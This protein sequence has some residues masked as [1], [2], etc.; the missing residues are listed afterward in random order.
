MPTRKTAYLAIIAAGALWGTI[1]IFVRTLTAAGFSPMQLI[2]FRAYISA[3]VL[4]VFLA[5]K[6]P[7]MLKIRLRDIWCFAG[8]GIAS[9]VLFNYCYFIAMGET[10]LSV[11][12]VLLYTAP[13]FVMLLSLLFFKEKMTKRKL[14]ALI[15]AFFGCVL[16]TGIFGQNLFV[17]KTGIIAGLL[18]GFL[19]ALYSI[20]GRY[21]LN[22]YHTF[23]V[24]A[25]TFVFASIGVTPMAD[26]GSIPAILGDNPSLLLFILLFAAVSGI[27]PYLLYTAGLSRVESGQASIIASVEPV[28]ATIIGVLFFH[29]SLT[30]AGVLGVIAV[31]SALFVLN[32][33][34][35]AKKTIDI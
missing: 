18:S 29:E 23:T 31:I 9:F 13:V 20:F 12:A 15:L 19:Y 2:A 10:S 26:L 14:I 30:P 8:T 16:V 28:V 11:A 21:A 6:N 4:V 24:T 33:R 3:A 7:G 25:Y 17:T 34:P 32:L 1:G 22:R 35:H 27:L 5:I